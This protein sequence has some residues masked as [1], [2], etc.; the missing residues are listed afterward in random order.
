[1]SGLE[2]KPSFVC[3]IML[4]ELQSLRSE[5]D[6]DSVFCFTIIYLSGMS[7]LPTCVSVYHAHCISQERVSGD[8]DSCEP[9]CGFWESNLSPLEEHPVG[10][11]SP[12]PWPYSSEKG[13]DI[14]NLRILCAFCST[15]C[16]VTQNC[17]RFAP[18]LQI[19]FPK[20]KLC[21]SPVPISV[22]HE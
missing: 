14:W 16:S 5:G 7:V 12:T 6:T 2:V 1:M 9:P 15:L 8:S 22:R 21:S 10:T 13:T 18:C 19:L 11:I 17:L 3:Y 20:A 4:N